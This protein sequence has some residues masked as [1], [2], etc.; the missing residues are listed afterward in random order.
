[1]KLKEDSIQFWDHYFKDQ[2]PIKINIEDIKV[3]NQFD[4]HLKKI[5]DYCSSVLDVGCGMGTSLMISKCLGR[6][7][8]KGIGFDS[9]Q[10]A[11]DFANET[12]KISGI[13]GLQYY[14]DD[15][16]FLKK[17]ENESFDGMICS[18][19]LDVIPKDL[20]EEIIFEMKRILKPRGYLLLKINFYLDEQQIKRLKM[21]NIDENTYQM[22]GVIRAYNLSTNDWIDRFSEL[23]VVSIS[24]FRRAPHL[25]EDRVILFKKQ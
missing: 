6:K 19:F 5:G 1:M 17:I 2:K 4:E 7:I 15:E 24:G 10:N 23:D 9:S 25:P 8:E 22:N 11:I 12:V 20:S 3:D 21:E 16:S 18:N 14:A 13:E